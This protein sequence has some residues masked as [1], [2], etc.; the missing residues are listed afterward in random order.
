[1]AR[2][3]HRQGRSQA[4]PQ[5]EEPHAQHEGQ[6][7]EEAPRAQGDD[8]RLRM[9]V[10]TP[11]G[12]GEGSERRLRTFLLGMKRPA[13]TGFKDDGFYWEIETDVKGYIALQ[14]KAVMFSS[15]AGGL[16]S[17]KVFKG[18][19]TKLGATKQQLREVE[20]MLTNGTSIEVIK[21]ATADEIVDGRTTWWE[22]FKMGFK[23]RTP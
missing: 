21:N 12:Q 11:A 15:L 14:K 10:R 23:H 18:A 13:E 3:S 2:T 7:V 9:V 1:M 19:A 6:D 17:N 4:G 5:R 16:A 22:K 20:D 8:V